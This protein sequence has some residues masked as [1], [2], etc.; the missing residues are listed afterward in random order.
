ML[1]T[2]NKVWPDIPPSIIALDA[3]WTKNF[4]IKN[5]NVPFC[6]SLVAIPLSADLENLD[7]NWIS[8]YVDKETEASA[9]IRRADFLLGKLMS[10]GKHVFCGHQFSS[11]LAAM[12]NFDP[13]IKTPYITTL[14]KLWHS[15]KT[16][17]KHEKIIDTRYDLEKYLSAIK[18]RRLVD[19]CVHLGLGVN[20]PELGSHSMTAL[21][22]RFLKTGDYS[23]R[24]R[25]SVMNLRHGLSCAVLALLLR[26]A[27]QPPANI[28]LN[29]PLY[30]NL[31]DYIPY[32][33]SNDFKELIL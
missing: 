2:H 27:W 16:E 25:L 4:H 9:L 19:V 20:Q 23:I 17:P 21:Q 10:S 28:N 12:A 13:S 6:F 5:G 1:I 32:A 30:C 3:E 11:D 15:R 18:S 29:A 24:D 31:K 7:F 14:R 33:K 8:V 22:R 26:E